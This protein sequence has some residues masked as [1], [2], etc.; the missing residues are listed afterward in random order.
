MHGRADTAEAL[1][2]QPGLARIATEKDVLDPAPHGAGRP[3][4][5]DLAAVDLGV[6]SEVAF[7]TGDGING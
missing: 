1:R 5:L 3:G 6:D 4:L 2:E 7:D